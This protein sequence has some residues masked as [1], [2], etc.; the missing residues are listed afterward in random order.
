M[1]FFPGGICLRLAIFGGTFDPIH[2]AHVTV[3]RE[4]A[5]RFA[6]DRVLFI[7]A[8]HPPHKAGAATSYEDRFR[9]VELAC[10]ADPRFEAS[11]LEQGGEKSYSFHTIR[12][13][14][15][16]LGP[17]DELFFLIGADAFAEVDTWYRSAEVLEMVDFLVVTRPGH[18]YRVPPGA[19]VH[20][21]EAIALPV[22]SSE[23]RKSVTEGAG[24]L[25]EPVLAYIRTHRLY[26]Y[27][28]GE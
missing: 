24:L 17:Q 20:R 3:A 21:L 8:A 10:A 4:A 25:P 22:S 14:R 13:V 16:Q 9:M 6:L 26:G 19:R 7:P 15:E 5:D 28:V 27:T 23:I 2:T 1:R 18:D 11:R 12:R